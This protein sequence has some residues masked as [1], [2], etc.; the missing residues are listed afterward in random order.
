MQIFASH[1]QVIE[2]RPTPGLVYLCL[3]PSFPAPSHL[4]MFP[5]PY[6]NAEKL[7][8]NITSFYAPEPVQNPTATCSIGSWD[9]RIRPRFGPQADQHVTQ[10]SRSMLPIPRRDKPVHAHAGK[11]EDRP[12]LCGETASRVVEGGMATRRRRESQPARP[13]DWKGRRTRH[14]VL[15]LTGELH[16][17]DKAISLS[18][19]IGLPLWTL[20]YEA[21]GLALTSTRNL[22]L[23]THAP[24]SHH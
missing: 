7:S 19:S 23:S 6:S 12:G 5:Q 9:P 17:T 11:I 10:P 16:L 15:K 24:T 18:C 2:S 3:W 20:L 13:F 1:P 14:G 4:K 22:E 21:L 8:E